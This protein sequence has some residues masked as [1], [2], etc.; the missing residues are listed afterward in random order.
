MDKTALWDTLD[1]VTGIAD[2]YGAE[3][4]LIAIAIGVV[5]QILALIFLRFVGFAL[6]VLSRLIAWLVAIAVAFYVLDL[7]TNYH[8]LISSSTEDLSHLFRWFLFALSLVT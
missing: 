1:Q 7:N 2:R 5:V 8:D 6:G 3:R 4:L